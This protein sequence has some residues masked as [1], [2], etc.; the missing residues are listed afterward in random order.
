MDYDESIHSIQSFSN[1]S[2]SPAIKDSN[3]R[4]RQRFLL[5][6]NRLDDNGILNDE[7]IDHYFNFLG[8]KF[9][10]IKFMDS[11]FYLSILLHGPQKMAQNVSKR[12]VLNFLFSSYFILLYRKIICLISSSFFFQF[13]LIIIGL[14][15][16]LMF[17]ENACATMIH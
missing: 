14:W 8:E 12:V 7:C 3:N 2:D 5:A 10:T 11:F 4:K 16:H 17:L 1:C 9:P 6:Y 15:P 13:L